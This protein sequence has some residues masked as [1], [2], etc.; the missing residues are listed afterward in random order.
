[1]SRELIYIRNYYSFSF[2]PGSTA[3][4]SPEAYVATRHRPLE[5]TQDKFFS[6]YS[7]KA[8][9]PKSHLGM[10]HRCDIRHLRDL[11]LLA[12]HESFDLPNQQLIFLF[13]TH[14]LQI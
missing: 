4:S 14:H 2:L 11:I 6:L 8:R 7:V 10:N 5:R 3:D 9:P 12:L 1:M 13:F